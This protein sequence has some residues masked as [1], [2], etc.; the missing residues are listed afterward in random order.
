MR[1]TGFS[2]SAVHFLRGVGMQRPAANC[3]QGSLLHERCCYFL[4]LRL[5]RGGSP[6]TVGIEVLTYIRYFRFPCFVIDFKQGF[7]RFSGYMNSV[8]VQ[9]PG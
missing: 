5:E 3:E 4:L 2:H 9:I 1:A 7:H 6:L 8:Q